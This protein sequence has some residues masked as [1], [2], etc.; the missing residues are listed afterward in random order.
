M[1]AK[2][3]VGRPSTYTAKVADA[4]CERVA[5]G[6]N[7]NLIC[8][9]KDLPGR[10]TVYKWL[11]DKPEFASNYARAREARADTRSDRIDDVMRR[12]LDGE[13]DP[14]AARIVID[15]EKWQA[16]KEAPKR[17]GDKVTNEHTGADGGAVQIN[18]VTGID[19]D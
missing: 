3:K 6:E 4:I 15:A 11:R 14:Q 12:V 10:D 2:K 7:L 9:G 13:L 17:Y 19:R 18:V 8:K 16:G 5:L 1:P